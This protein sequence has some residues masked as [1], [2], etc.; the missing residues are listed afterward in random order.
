MAA[1]L[2]INYELCRALGDAGAV[3]HDATAILAYLYQEMFNLK[4]IGLRVE[5]GKERYG[6]C[7]PV[8]HG[9]NRAANIR[10]AT[11]FNAGAASAEWALGRIANCIVNFE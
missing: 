11:D 8:S 3:M 4:P 1:V 5:C 9:A 10:A 6:K 2:K 7:L